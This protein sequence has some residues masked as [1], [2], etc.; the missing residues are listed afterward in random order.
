MIW[1]QWPCRTVSCNLQQRR[2]SRGFLCSVILSDSELAYITT[3]SWLSYLM[4]NIQTFASYTGLWKSRHQVF[5]IFFS[6]PEFSFHRLQAPCSTTERH[7][8]EMRPERM[9]MQ[10]FEWSNKYI[11]VGLN[12]TLLPKTIFKVYPFQEVD[13][14]SGRQDE[15]HDRP[16]TQAIIMDWTEQKENLTFNRQRCFF[17]CAFVLGMN[18][19]ANSMAMGP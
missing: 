4:I 19:L 11:F 8:R 13:K 18:V 10:E 7:P 12:G 9:H 15:D 16:C 3:K 14:R 17:V 5:A 1:V 2:S 6:L